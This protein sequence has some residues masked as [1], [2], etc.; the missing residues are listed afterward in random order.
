[1]GECRSY[2]LAVSLGANCSAAHNLLVRGLRPFSLPFDWLYIVD[3]RPI[4]YLAKGFG[5]R[6][7]DFCLKE[8]LKEIRPGDP[9]YAAAHPDRVQYADEATGFRFVNHF[10]RSAEDPAE[11]ARVRDML[12][13]R[14]DRLY[15]AFSSGSRFLLL[16]ATHVDVSEDV[17]RAVLDALGKEFPGKSFDIEYLHFGQ[18]EESVVVRDCLRIRNV[19]R[20]QNEYDFNRTNWE[21]RFLDDV[22]VLT[23]PRK[24]RK[25]SFRVWPGLDCVIRLERDR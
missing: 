10:N 18:P 14:I 1:M 19:R 2:D 23:R 7:A 15:E 8:N 21:W 5:N 24:R 11:Y 13:R 16:L 6:F 3:E 17:L 4:A 12:S 25:I 20:P 22:R 9:E